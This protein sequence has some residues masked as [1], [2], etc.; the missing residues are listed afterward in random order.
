MPCDTPDRRKLAEEC[1]D[2]KEVLT[3]CPGIRKCDR[4]R[5]ALVCRVFPFEPHCD[6]NGKM[7]GLAYNYTPE[8]PCPLRRRRKNI[9]NP[10][11]LRNA[12]IVWRDILDIF[13]E[14]KELY[15]EESRKL[16][17]RFKRLGRRVPIF[18]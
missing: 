15:I 12:M 10:A 14:E 17:R 2:W 7:I 8:I 6:P 1:N 4:T 5:R 3:L 11:Y 9:Y 13:P 16:R 18:K